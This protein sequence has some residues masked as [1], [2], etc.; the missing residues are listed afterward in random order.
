GKD[1]CILFHDAAEGRAAILSQGR[2]GKG[3]P[4]RVIPLESFHVASI[5]IDLMIGA[6]AYGASQ[7]AILVTEKTAESY[8]AAL[9]QQMKYAQT[10]VTALGYAGVHFSI[11]ESIERIWEL[12]AAATAEKPAG[13]NLSADKR[14][15]LDFAFD[16]LA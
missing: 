10:I 5:G 15:S 7:V 8:V 14:T 12:K 2:K 1:A 4:A 16:H 11:I 13:F 9:K 6:I 3:L